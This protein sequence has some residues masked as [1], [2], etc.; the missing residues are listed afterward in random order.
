MINFS[1]ASQVAGPV[2]VI[3]FLQDGNCLGQT[4]MMYFKKLAFEEIVIRSDYMKITFEGCERYYNFVANTET[5]GGGAQ[6]SG[7]LGK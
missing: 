4:E 3:L 5:S 6:N 1:A 7:T 2:P